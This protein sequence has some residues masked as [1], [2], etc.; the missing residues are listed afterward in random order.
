MKLRLLA[1]EAWRILHTKIPMAELDD[2]AF[3]RSTREQLFVRL[4]RLDS[5][6]AS[7]A[8]RQASTFSLSL[9]LSRRTELWKIENGIKI[10]HVTTCISSRWYFFWWKMAKVCPPEEPQ[11]PLNW[12]IE[13][14][15]GE[16]VRLCDPLTQIARHTADISRWIEHTSRFAV[17]R[18]PIDNLLDF[19]GSCIAINSRHLTLLSL[20]PSFSSLSVYPSFLCVCWSPLFPLCGVLR[21][22]R[23]L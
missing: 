16:K 1:F 2:P 10:L 20:S 8:S 9:C 6:D 22:E 17:G 18:S 15:T 5:M 4:I 3:S 14:R 13:S 21:N 7:Q 19:I 12:K 11:R 23:K